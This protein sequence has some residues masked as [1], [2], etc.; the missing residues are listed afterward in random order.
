MVNCAEGPVQDCPL[1]DKLGVTVTKELATE[2]VLEFVAVNTG[3]LPVPG[4]VKPMAAL[5]LVQE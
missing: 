2:V 4:P 3:M 5:A 1:K